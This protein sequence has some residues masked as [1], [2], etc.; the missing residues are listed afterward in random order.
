M[1][2]LLAED[3]RLTRADGRVVE[4]AGIDGEIE[5]ALLDVL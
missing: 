2:E 3:A 1:A 5:R 4:A